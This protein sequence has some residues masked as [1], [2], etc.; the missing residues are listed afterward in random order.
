LTVE[1]VISTLF[2]RAD[3]VDEGLK[4][5]GV[6][7]GAVA[8][9]SA[10]GVTLGVFEEKPREQIEMWGFQGTAMGFLVG[11]LALYSWVILD[12]H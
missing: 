6:L 9:G 11:L 7:L 5:T 4:L 10:L 1:V 2:L 12:H 8:L 3:I